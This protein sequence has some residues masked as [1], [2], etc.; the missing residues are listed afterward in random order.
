MKRSGK[1]VKIK[2]STHADGIG[3]DPTPQVFP[4]LD[5][6]VRTR[7]IVSS[8]SSFAWGEFRRVARR[9]VDNGGKHAHCKETPVARDTKIRGESATK[10]SLRN[11]LRMSPNLSRSESACFTKHD[12]NPSILKT[13]LGQTFHAQTGCEISRLSAVKRNR[14]RTQFDD[15]TRVLTWQHE[16]SRRVVCGAELAYSPGSTNQAQDALGTLAEETVATY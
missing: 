7:F 5:H 8:R 11:Q 12:R 3:Y 13:N 9:Y 4:T 6:E 10:H 14:P 1:I 2:P 16:P 15:G